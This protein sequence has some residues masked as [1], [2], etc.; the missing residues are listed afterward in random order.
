MI[1]IE[2]T[3]FEKAPGFRLGYLE[4][5]G[6]VVRNSPE[7]FWDE[8]GMEIEKIRQR[9]TLK[10]LVEDAHISGV[11]K[12]YRAWGMD[13]TRYRQSAERLHR[14]LLKGNDLY[15][16]NT[17][18]DVCNRVSLQFRLPL[19]LYDR[20]KVQGSMTL[21]YGRDGESY[22]AVTEQ[23][24]GAGGRVVVC[25]DAGPIGSP[26]TDSRRTSV[27][28]STTALVLLV[29]G[30]ENIGGGPVVEAMETYRAMLS[31]LQPE[32]LAIVNRDVLLHKM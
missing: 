21:R 1:T 6:A 26:T 32:K 29:Y 18:V 11:R 8:F 16:I 17:A 15:R 27:D 28:E 7:S 22:L 5:D 12:L 24:I 3:I 2:R 23:E 19:G 4:L 30:P 9:F 10:N 25:D 31:G 20:D 13:P 14:R